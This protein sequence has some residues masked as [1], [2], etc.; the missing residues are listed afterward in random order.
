[1]FKDVD[2]DRGL[3]SDAFCLAVL[4]IPVAND[5]AAVLRVVEIFPRLD[6]QGF[7]DPIGTTESPASD[8]GVR[9][10]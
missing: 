9:Y 3:V 4:T 2:W 5:F 7:N 6:R 10:R 8:G 1:L